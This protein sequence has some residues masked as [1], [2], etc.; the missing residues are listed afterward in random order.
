MGSVAARKVGEIVS[1]DSMSMAKVVSSL[2]HSA[3]S[4][5][6]QSSCILLRPNSAFLSS[7]QT[8]RER[9]ESSLSF[10]LLLDLVQ[11]PAEFFLL[12]S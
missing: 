10:W 4:S 12:S 2:P 8:T 3:S 9:K 1:N 5:S 7:L 11:G 6:F